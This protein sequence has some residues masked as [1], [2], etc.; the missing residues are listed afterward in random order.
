[1]MAYGVSSYL[2]LTEKR[3]G[4][5]NNAADKLANIIGKSPSKYKSV[6]ESPEAAVIKCYQ[7][8]LGVNNIIRYAFDWNSYMGKVVVKSYNDRAPTKRTEDTLFD[9]IGINLN[10]T[11]LYLDYRRLHDTL[12]LDVADS[13]VY[14]KAY[15][16]LVLFTMIL[17]SQAA[18]VDSVLGA[19]NLTN[20]NFNENLLKFIIKRTKLPMSNITYRSTYSN[21]LYIGDT[22]DSLISIYKAFEKTYPNLKVVD[23]NDASK[24]V[25][26]LINYL[27]GGVQ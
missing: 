12:K 19:Q 14:H 11:Y 18:V 9:I 2:W 15:F 1:M 6:I 13:K 10:M 16:N 20:N 22:T 24:S 7:E 27:K 26:K 21:G 17:I 3:G 23:V 4:A 5:R 8:L 25:Q